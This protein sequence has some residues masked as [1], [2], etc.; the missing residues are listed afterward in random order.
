M[1]EC[2]ARS[3]GPGLN[4]N[5]GSFVDALLDRDLQLFGIGGKRWLPAPERP[6]LQRFVRL[7]MVAISDDEL[8]ADPSA[9]PHIGDRF[10]VDLAA[11]HGGDTGPQYRNEA[12]LGPGTRLHESAN[13]VQL[14]L[15]DVDEEH[16]RAAL[17]QRDG[18]LLQ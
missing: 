13:A 12:R 8:A 17:L 4:V 7:E 18:E 11:V 6:C 3:N 15:L 10:E 2:G 1:C 14:I 5:T 16:V 9:P